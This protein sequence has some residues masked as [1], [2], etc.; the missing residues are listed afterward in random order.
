MFHVKHCDDA[1]GNRAGPAGAQV[2]ACQ[3]LRVEGIGLRTRLVYTLDTRCLV[4]SASPKLSVEQA[5]YLNPCAGGGDVSRET[6]WW[7]GDIAVYRF[8]D[9][10]SG[11]VYLA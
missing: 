6:S 5:W 9:G 10:P 2:S 4:M 3:V 11:V 1:S 8:V 7:C